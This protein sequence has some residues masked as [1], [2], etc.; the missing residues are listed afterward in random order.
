MNQDR[1]ASLPGNPVFPRAFTVSAAWHGAMAVGC[2]VTPHWWPF[3]LGGAALNH[4]VLGAASVMPRGQW[5]GP[6]ITQLP[7]QARRRNQVC[8][9]FDDGPDPQLTPQVLEILARYGATASFFCIG[10]QVEKHADIVR[11]IASAGHS[12]E[13]HTATHHHRF[14][15]RASD[16][17]RQE[18]AGAQQL[19]AAAGAPTPRFFRAPAGMRNPLL[20]TVLARQNLRLTSWT[21]RGFDTVGKHPDKILDRLTRNLAP[22]DILLLHDRHYAQSPTHREII[23]AVLPELLHRIRAAGLSSVSLPEAFS[24]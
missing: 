20:Q 11:A 5:L 9:T 14:A 1:P 22:G 18:I 15:F 10:T 21:R 24:V 19:I 6:N 17:L 2:A 12:V 13:N 3:W 8:L 23:L 7:E 16:G 4:G